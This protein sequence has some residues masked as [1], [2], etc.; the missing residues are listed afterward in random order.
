VTGLVAGPVTGPLAIPWAGFGTWMLGPAAREHV[1]T[2]LEVGY[3]HVDTAPGYGNEAEVGQAIE[4]SG[5]ARD[6]LF[7]VA[8]LHAEARGHER[9]QIRRTLDALMIERADL[10]LVHGPVWPGAMAAWHALAE[11]QAEGRAAAI[12]VSNYMPHEI[13]ALERGIGVR[14]AANQ[15]PIGPRLFLQPLLDE[16]AARQVQV[17]AHSPFSENDLA[18]PVLV[19]LA[20]GRGTSVAPLLL[21]WHVDHGVPYVV[22]SSDPAHIRQNFCPPGPPLTAAE[23]AAIDACSTLDESV[24]QP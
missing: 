22:R 16:Y 19:A 14:P 2:A 6:E 21:R 23:M 11:A 18:H 1:S 13:D 5:L 12:G 7:V 17:I 24:L 10:Y 3:R 20:H 8:K 4:R 15:I 9:D